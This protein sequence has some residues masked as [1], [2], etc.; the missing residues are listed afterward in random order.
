MDPQADSDQ[1]LFEQE[2]YGVVN[3]L[4]AE[5]AKPFLGIPSN[6]LQIGHFIGLLGIFLMAFV[7]YPGF[8]LTNLPTPLRYALQGGLGSVFAINLV[9]AILSTFEARK[10]DQPTILWAVKTFALGGLAY[11]QLTQIST[12]E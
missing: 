4:L 10:R 5:G 12:V 1:S 6:I 8:P 11:D 7:E 2:K 9:L 3:A